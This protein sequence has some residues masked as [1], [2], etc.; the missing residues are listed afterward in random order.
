MST[1]RIYRYTAIARP[2][3]PR[4]PTN[5]AVLL[6][7]PVVAILTALL[8]MLGFGGGAAPGSAAL[9][10]ALAAFGAWAV[11]RELAPDD[12]PAAFVA[13]G[14]AVAATLWL[15]PHSALPLFV[16]LFLTRIVNRSTGTHARWTD[17]V[18]VTAFVLW[19]SVTLQDPL[20]GLAACIAF[21]LDASLDRPARFQLAFGM[22]CL[23]GSM[24]LVVRDGVA[25][26]ALA[27]LEGPLLWLGLLVLTAFLFV[28]FTTSK[29]ASVGDVSG[30][31]LNT[32]R[33][34]SGM[35]VAGL[36]AAQ[37]PVLSGEA[38]VNPLLWAC[39]ASVALGRTFTPK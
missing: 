4:F 37:A 39:L 20:L 24:L 17:S 38:G 7:V 12:N 15:G 9:G 29:L 13:M 27:E 2:V 23:L 18:L 21:F 10:A 28:L 30:Q 8:A 1:H 5:K 22:V 32:P 3:D 11:T 25:M 19:A 34:R 6:I 26:P 31:P 33:V 35:F 16:A 14:L 36:L